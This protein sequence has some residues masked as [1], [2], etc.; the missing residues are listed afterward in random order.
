MLDFGFF[1]NLFIQLKFPLQ[2]FTTPF[3]QAIHRYD[4]L[5]YLY[6]LSGNLIMSSYSTASGWYLS[7]FSATVDTILSSMGHKQQLLL[8]SILY[9]QKRI[10]SVFS[11]LS[12]TDDHASHKICF[13]SL[14]VTRSGSNYVMDAQYLQVGMSSQVFLSRYFYDSRDSQI[15]AAI[16]VHWKCAE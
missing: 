4:T 16:E 7:I 6:L 13:F 3:N 9:Q 14:L 12:T 10:R 2:F 11:N 1:I 5:N 8:F 15:A